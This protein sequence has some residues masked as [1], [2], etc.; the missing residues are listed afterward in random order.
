MGRSNNKKRTVLVGLATTVTL[1]LTGGLVT[2]AAT[3]A[4]AATTCASP[5]YKRQI[6]A[7]TTFSGTPKKTAC[8]AAINE[9]WG[10]KAPASG[11]PSN[12]FGVRWTVTRDFGSGGPFTFT[13]AAQD[14]IR[15][16]VDGARKISLWK[17][18]SSTV[19]KTLNFSM[20]YGKHTLRIDYV[21][22]TGKANVKFTYGPR[23]SASVDKTKPLP[24]TGFAVA[25]DKAT[26]KA[27]LTW[28]SNKE[29]DLVGYRVY[30]RL[31]TVDDWTALL[32]TKSASYT[33]TPPAAGQ[34]YVYQVRAYDK[35]NNYSRATAEKSIVTVDR[36]APGAPS[37]YGTVNEDGAHLSWSMVIDEAASYRVYRAADPNGV[38]TLVGTTQWSW[39]TDTSIPDQSSFFYRV[40]AVDAAGNE[41]APSEVVEGGRDGVPP[42][43]VTGLT[44]TPTEYGFELSWDASPASDASYYRLYRGTVLI[45]GEQRTCSYYEVGDWTTA[46]SMTY[47]TAADGEEACFF[48]NVVDKHGNSAFTSV[49]G[50][51]FRVSTELDTRPSLT[52]PEGS[53]LYLRMQQRYDGSVRME[54]TGLEVSSPEAAGGYRVY[55][56][57]PETSAYEKLAE[58]DQNTFEYDDLDPAPGTTH[59]YWVTAVASDGTESL[60]AGGA[61]ATGP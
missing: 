40:T 56:W 37:L 57:N 1:A 60:P 45:S 32:A 58:V 53:P 11:V 48:V 7:N 43:P 44:P 50:T 41:S 13:A 59:Y 35:A 39:F 51:G 12:N 24:P 3:P 49:S 8:D 55:R 10:T 31:E 28:A 33:D 52:T 15:V 29:M 5:V 26:G 38:F 2:V 34:T 54:W 16:Y 21:N 30:R 46:T 22:W 14:G 6:F 27:K 20:P 17:N 18:V 25:Y 4:A 23:T 47:L 61:A 42:P 36:T 9:N 19:S